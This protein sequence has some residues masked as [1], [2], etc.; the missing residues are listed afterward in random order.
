MRI[1]KISIIIILGLIIISYSCF[2]IYWYFSIKS[3]KNKV[4]E[5]LFTGAIFEQN[6][7]IEK[8]NEAF[9]NKSIIG[10]GEAT[11]GTQEIRDA[12]CDLAKMLVEKG[13]INVIAFAERD[14]CE[15]LSTNYF[16]TGDS[17][18]HI[19]Q[20]LFPYSSKKE[21]ELILWVQEFNK[22]KANNHKIW[23]LG[24][25]I[26]NTRSAAFQILKMA[27]KINIELTSFQKQALND[28]S[29]LPFFYNIYK[30]KYSLNQINGIC[31]S[32]SAAL[33]NIRL[34]D[35][36]ATIDLF[37]N[38]LE[39]FRCSIELS[40]NHPDDLRDNSMFKNL[41]WIRNQRSAKVLIFGH[42][43]HL[44]KMVGNTLSSKV[45]RLGHYIYKAYPEDYV[46]I[47]SE[48]TKGKYRSGPNK[49]I[50]RIP[51]DFN[52]IGNILEQCTQN[53]SNGYL[54]WND[55]KIIQTFFEKDRYI[56]FGLL[57][58][59]VPT[60]PLHKRSVDAFDILYW[61]R[62]S[63]PLIAT[64]INNFTFL[65]AMDKRDIKNVLKNGSLSLSIQSSFIPISVD[66][67]NSSPYIGVNMFSKKKSTGYYLFK[68]E[69]LDS[70]QNFN[71]KI[72]SICDSLNIFLYGE[73]SIEYKFKNFKVG[74]NKLD[75]KSLLYDG[76]SY[77]MT[78]M[79]RTAV[80]IH[81]KY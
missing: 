20:M 26:F 39:N 50:F 9:V 41:N 70:D 80:A 58:T 43:A 72:S 1:F 37:V 40:Y 54:F 59:D 57:D 12:F 45:K 5:N 74:Q 4:D 31:D 65:H 19:G 48:V 55:D 47:G 34:K 67:F 25:D 71:L 49:R 76:E 29:G 68:L 42:D 33:S 53:I 51:E 62:N 21:K 75:F 22:T 79:D 61:T 18:V 15:S 24:L 66:N 56:T 38:V 13:K 73:S 28:I 77:H 17:S 16:I 64:S 6:R 78:Y 2:K 3:I 63:S 30:Q 23:I 11:H 35:K 81:L 60:D 14:F 44:E 7:T 69:N 8:L 10:F 52:K 32:L 36:M 27:N 46:N